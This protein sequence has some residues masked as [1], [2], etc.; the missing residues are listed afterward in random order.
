MRY[1][2]HVAQYG[3]SEELHNWNKSIEENGNGVM[4]LAKT[5][6]ENKGDLRNILGQWAIQ[7]LSTS[8]SQ[9]G[10][11][12]AAAVQAG[13]MLAGAPAGPAGVAAT[14]V[15]TLPFTMATLSGVTA[16][17]QFLVEELKKEVGEDFD[18]DAILDALENDEFRADLRKNA[19]IYGIGV[20]TIDAATMKLGGGLAAQQMRTGSK[21]LPRTKLAAQ[22]AVGEG[23]GGAIGEGVAGTAAGRDVTPQEM[24]QEF[25]AGSFNTPITLTYGALK[26]GKMS[27][28]D[29]PNASVI[30]QLNV[31][32]KYEINGQKFSKEDFTSIIDRMTPEELNAANIK[33]EDDPATSEMVGKRFEAANKTPEPL[34]PRGCS[35]CH[36]RS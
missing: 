24:F 29:N 20:G 7:S 32:S 17:T 23:A 36:V 19:A 9:E 1:D 2:A 25:A 12:K 26:E 28:I 18:A 35:Q 27:M 33:V 8:M 4:G 30:N 6:W 31:R 11:E 22:V 10:L 15:A 13:G 21:F 14:G 34:S 3:T 5:I 16:S